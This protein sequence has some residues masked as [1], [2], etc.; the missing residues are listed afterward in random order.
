VQIVTIHFVSDEQGKVSAL[1]LRQPSTV[2]TA[3]R[4]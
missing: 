4:K 1:E 2:L 3:K